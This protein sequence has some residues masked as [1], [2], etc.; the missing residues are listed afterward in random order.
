M[1]RTG[2]TVVVSGIWLIGALAAVAVVG[3]LGAGPLQ[4]I[5]AAV[6]LLVAV[7]LTA[8]LARRAE[9]T[10]SAEL[11][12]LAEA[13]GVAEDFGD[14][15]LTLTAVIGA[16]V[17]RMARM[18]PFKPAFL[19]LER[20]ALVIDG[21]GAALAATAGCR[22][23][24]GG[25]GEP[26]LAALFGPSFTPPEPGGPAKLAT[27]GGVRVNVRR[28]PLAGNLSLVELV[29]AG[30]FVADDD[31][32]A[33]A[34]ALASDRTS[35]RFDPAAAA[36]APALA[37]LNAALAECDKIGTAM[38]DLLDGRPVD[39]GFLSANGGLAP[40]FRQ[41]HD[42]VLGL[43]AEL[44]AE[45]DA[46]DS[47]EEKLQAIGRVI[48]GYHAAA[49]RVGE[50][51]GSARG[52]VELA[53][54]ALTRL[55]AEAAAARQLEAA[56]SGLAGQAVGVLGRTADVIG[57]MDRMATALERF[58]S[59]I[60]DIS[61]RT[62]LL[63]LNA[64][65][66][67]AR[68]GESGAGFAVVA[69]EVRTLARSSQQTTTE[70]RALVAGARDRSAGGVGEAGQL[71]KI[72]AALDANLRNLSDAAEKIAADVEAGGRA[73]ARATSDLD[74]VDGQAQRALSLPRRGA[75]AA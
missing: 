70:I 59:T 67:A 47:Y 19:A 14:D 4:L 39:P 32:D 69:E 66:E 68:A 26:S 56:S 44:D 11:A 29:P 13:A 31:L 23:M 33:F 64:A 72:L 60:E 53:G 25:D 22:R 63:A 9:R 37:A 73:L 21:A 57:E 20:P 65:V 8:F 42:A 74:A 58:V 5:D 27:V 50:L 35:F 3:C 51:A 48:D 15:R 46:R 62:N 1:R 2:L 52:E 28:Q 16:L 40:G 43:G 30:Q 38:A 36:E 24:L 45:R 54:A 18:Q 17:G 7:G 6:P 75:R 12:A 61:F 34:E 41:L 71:K 55:A 49:E 10:A